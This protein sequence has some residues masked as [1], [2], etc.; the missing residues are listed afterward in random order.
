MAHLILVIEDDLTL[1]RLIVKQLDA[2]G[3][4]TTGARS[5]KEADIYL[6]AHEP[7]LVITDVRLADGDTLLRLHFLV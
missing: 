5:W 2:Q 1:N 6:E 7:H 3:Y 4:Q